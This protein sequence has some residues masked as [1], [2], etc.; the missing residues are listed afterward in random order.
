MATTSSISQT[1]ILLLKDLVSVKLDATNYVIWKYQILSIFET[2]S[3]VDMLDGTVPP[4]E[5]YL[6]DENGD[7][8]LHENILYKQWKARDQALKTLINATLSPSAITLVI[9]QT[10]AQGV[11]Q[12]LERRYTSLSRTHI[13]S[14]KAELD[15]VKKS[16]T[17]TITVYLDRVKEI[18]DKLGSVGVIVDDE[19]LLH[20]VLKGLPAEYDPFCSA[21]RT[22]DRAIS[23]EE[24]HVLLTSEEESKKNVKHGGN[25]QPHMAMAATH[26]QFFTPTTNNPLPLLSAPWNRGRGGRGNNRGRG[27]RNSNRGGFSSNSQGFASNPLGFSPNYNSSG[28]SQRPQCQICGKTGHLALDCFHRMNFA[29][30]GRQPPAKLAAIASTA[31]SSAINAPYSNQSSWIS[32]TGATDHFTPDISHIPDC[33]DYRGTDQVTVGN[34]QSLP[35]THTGNSQLYASSHLFKLRKILHVPSMSSNLLSVHR[36]CKDNNASFYFDASKFRIKDLSSGRLLYNGPSEHGLYPI[37]GAI[38]P[39]SSPKLFHTS[40][41]SSS[42]QL[43]H[44]RLG[45][46]QQSVVKHVLQ[47]KLRLPVSNTTSLCIHCLEGKMHKLPFPN[48]VSITSHPLEIVHS[49]VWG[50]APITSNNETRYY[51]TFV[52]DFTRFTW[53]FPLQSKSQVLSSFMHFKSTMEN[54]LSCK[55]KI[56]R[57]DCGGEYTKHDFQSFCSSTGVFHQ[58]TCPHTSQQNGVAERKHRHIVDMGLTLMSQASLPL[59]FWPYAFSTAVF[60]IN[61]LPSPHRGLISPWESLFGSSPPYSIFRSFG[62]ACYP[63]LRPYS[64]HKLL[65]RS[66]QCIFLGYPSNAKGFLCFD[67]V[68]SRFFVSRHVT[69]DESVFP[70]H[71]L[72]ST[73]SF[74][75]LP[76]HSQASNP[77]W[78][79]ALLY[80][81]SCSLPSLLGAPPTPVLNSTNMPIPPLAPTSVTVLSS[82]PVV[83]SS[84]APV[85]TSSTAPVPTSSTAPVPSSSTA[86]VTAS[87]LT[88][89]AP[90]SPLVAN[91]HPMQTRGKSGITKK[92]QLLLTKSAPDY[93]HTEPPSFSVARTIPQWHEAMASEFAAL[94]RQST[95]SLVPPSPDHHIIGCH[96]VFKLKRNSDGSVARY[97]ARLVA[98]G[99]HQM[100]GIDFAETFS[101]VVKPATVRLILS[102]AAQNQWSLRQLD[103][104]NAFLH[105]SLK[106]C[107]FMSQPPGFVDSTAPSHVCLLHKSIYGLRQAPRAWFEKFSSHLLTV[108][109]TASQA[110]PSLFIYRHGSTV[111]YLLLYVDDIIITGN[112]STAVTELITNLASVFELK[113]LG[114][115]KFFLGLQIDYKTSGF[116]VHQSKYALDVLS[117]H[118]MT[119][120]KPCTSPFVSCSKLSSDVVEFLLDPTPYR[121]L[122]GALQYLTF[123]RPDLSFAVNSLCQHMQNPTSAHMVAAKRVLRYVRG[124]LSHGILFQP[125]P[126]HLTVFTDAD[127]AGNPVDRRSTTG[128]LVFLGNNLLTWASKK[129]PT[130]SRSSTEAEYRSLAVGAAE[131]A[132]IRMLLCDLHIFPSLSSPTLV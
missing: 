125:G 62:C 50:P 10:T 45:H 27:G 13:L 59:T 71:K 53:F 132:W 84:T 83:P 6:A 23:C 86:P 109:F 2:Y 111:L 28:T 7:L 42:S 73:P 36:F 66:V 77:A 75:H 5:Q 88:P 22:R 115:L 37:H 102:I 114:P 105:G 89:V 35:I 54:L 90:S 60:L 128:F 3:L 87:S 9:G 76:A 119:T 16:T 18:R 131:V 78:L 49:D 61:R 11:W 55:L 38:L 113:D 8:S 101:P 17:E 51:V 100:P 94:T 44:N 33:H 112:H 118:N 1:P 21:M 122:V 56:L 81:H 32:D 47:N 92:K 20:T 4:P 123:T 79:S 126:M 48:S 24:L 98:K 70:F 12:V 74:S 107:V 110:D 43:W 34:G 68:S 39:A 117:R 65:P 69:F 97:K 80:F 46:P 40:A 82:V 106:E 93:L 31:M 96:W 72:S 25:D 130:V 116:F 15:R 64:K 58:F 99:N 85:S 29:Y 127:W 104:S 120:C 121:S 41:V 19:D 57:T 67:P 52:D 124:T 91:A 30:Q 108:G 129:Q 14:L 26:S 63:L 103:V 95:W